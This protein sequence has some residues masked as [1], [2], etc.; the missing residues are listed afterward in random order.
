M[1]EISLSLE[2]DEKEL[3]VCMEKYHFSDSDAGMIQYLYENMRLLLQPKV[4]YT[5]I[6][7]RLFCAVTLGPLIDRLQELFEAADK[8]LPSYI[9]DCLAMELLGKAYEQMSYRIY[10][11]CGLWVEAYEFFGAEEK[12]DLSLGKM[13]KLLKDYGA[14]WVSCNEAYQLLPAKSVVFFARLTAERGNS[15]CKV[16]ENCGNTACLYREN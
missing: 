1:K 4:E 3:S 12:E 15:A 5:M 16:C 10:E 13:S 9:I 2:L 6:S 14:R 8:I 11:E 7:E